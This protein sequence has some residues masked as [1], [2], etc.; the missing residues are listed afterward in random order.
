MKTIGRDMISGAWGTRTSRRAFTL[1]ELLVSVLIFS[2]LI[3]VLYSTLFGSLRLRERAHDNEYDRLPHERLVTTLRADIRS[4]VVPA[5]I[6]AGPMLGLRD[7]AGDSIEFFA[8]NGVVTA[9]EPWGDIQKIEYLLDDPQDGESPDGRVLVRRTTRNL[10]ATTIDEEMPGTTTWRLADGVETM[11]IL[12]YDG[13][14][15]LESWDSTIVENE[16]PQAIRVRMEFAAGEVGARVRPPVDVVATIA[17][18]PR[19]VPLVGAVAA[20]T[21]GGGGGPQ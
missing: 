8:A 6:L 3:A 20:S 1:L 12:Y 19:P 5:G 16:I 9:R 2:I 7:S 4:A 18:Q 11:T 21:G 15:W 17:T 13:T 10:L 14:S